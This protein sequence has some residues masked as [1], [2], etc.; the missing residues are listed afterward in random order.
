MT[1]RVEPDLLRRFKLV[2]V[3]QGRGMS[4]ILREFMDWYA[5]KEGK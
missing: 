1:V 2:A 3:A 4:E 5:T